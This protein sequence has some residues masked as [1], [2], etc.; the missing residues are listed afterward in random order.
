MYDQ[1]LCTGLT[2]REK[3]WFPVNSS[4]PVVDIT[5]LKGRDVYMRVSGRGTNIE[6]ARS[7]A[8]KKLQTALNL[9]KIMVSHRFV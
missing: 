7:T 5:L 2:V 9:K 3:I 4:N 6:F 1:F 8:K